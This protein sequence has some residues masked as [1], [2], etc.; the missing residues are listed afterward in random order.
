MPSIDVT[1]EDDDVVTGSE[2]TAAN[3][4][5]TMPASTTSG[6]SANPALGGAI[7]RRTISRGSSSESQSSESKTCFCGHFREVNKRKY[8]S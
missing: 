5:T 7:P 4:N 1:A 8:Y 6:L 3:D 2:P